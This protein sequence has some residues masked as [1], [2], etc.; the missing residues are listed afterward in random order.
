MTWW[1]TD[2]MAFA[3]GH[4]CL[5]TVRSCGWR[6]PANFTVGPSNFKEYHWRKAPQVPL[7]QN[8]I[9]PCRNAKPTGYVRINQLSGYKN[10]SPSWGHK[11]LLELKTRPLTPHFIQAT[12][13]QSLSHSPLQL[14][15][16]HLSFLLTYKAHHITQAVAAKTSACGHQ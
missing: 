6:L 9:S 8:T 11:L 12:Q 1:W 5:T 16:G 15:Q 7:P 2:F 13:R 14:H 3:C 4:Q 10:Q